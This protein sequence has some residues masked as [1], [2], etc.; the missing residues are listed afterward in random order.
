M[1]AC[2]ADSTEVRD[3][4]LLTRADLDGDGSPEEVRLT[5]S[6][7]AC[8]SMVFA[9]VGESYVAGQ[10]PADSP[11]VSEAF[12]VAV[13]GVGPDLLVTRQQHPRGGYQ[14]RIFSLSDNTLVEARDKESPLVKFIA[15]DVQEHP[16]SID[17]TEGGLVLVEALAHEPRGVIFAW[18]V[19]RKT[20]AVA[21]G[22]VTLE[23]T[24]EIADNVLPAQLEKKF[25]RLADYSLFKSCR[26]GG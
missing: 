8:P 3:A 17:C 6:G 24:K 18:D 10:V 15:T 14:I 9:K 13:P 11:P 7:G 21:S 23:S 22:A 4:T 5:G 2:T 25:P 26:V 1:G 19:F 16:L 12:A 20:Y